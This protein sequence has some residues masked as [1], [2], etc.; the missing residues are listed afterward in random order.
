ML[1]KYPVYDISNK[2]LKL[3]LSLYEWLF[4][5][6]IAII[7][8][9]LFHTSFQMFY[10][11]FAIALLVVGLKVY[12]IGKPDRFIKSLILYYWRNKVYFVQYKFEKKNDNIAYKL[13]F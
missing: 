1:N 11:L 7:E 10:D 13:W 9:E 6:L 8:F 3:G 2:V 5:L 4:V 12:K